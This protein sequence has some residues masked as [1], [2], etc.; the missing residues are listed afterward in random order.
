MLHP[1]QSD[2]L[3]MSTEFLETYIYIFFYLFI[4]LYVYIYIYIYSNGAKA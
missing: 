3:M 1:V 4:Y 2:L